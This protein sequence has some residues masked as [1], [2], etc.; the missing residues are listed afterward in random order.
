[1]RIAILFFIL[2]FI[3]CMTASA[4]NRDLA[5]S[6]PKTEP[7]NE[8]DSVSASLLI[9]IGDYT[10]CLDDCTYRMGISANCDE[11]CKNQLEFANNL[12]F[13]R[14]DYG[15]CMYVCIRDCRGH[16]SDSNCDDECHEACT[17][18]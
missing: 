18:E 2:I 13:P 14:A 10:G 8:S 6:N 11:V 16:K 17:R 4:N 12:L 7:A 9:L 1:M 5:G 15:T 3:S